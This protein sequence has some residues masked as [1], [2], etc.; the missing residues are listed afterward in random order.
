MATTNDLKNGLVL[1]LDGG[2]LWAVV[3]FQ[4][5]KPGKGGAFVRT[6]LKNV[7]SGKVVDKTFNAGVKVEVANVDKREMQFSY[8]DGDDFVFMDT[9]NY[10]MINVSRASVGSSADYLLENMLATLAINEGNVLYVDLPAAVEL[11]IAETEP[12]LQGDRSTGGTKPAKLETGA[13]IKVPLFITTGEKVKVDTRT[14]DY[15]GRA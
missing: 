2:E 5:V 10:D 8:M 15:L 6:K 3:E 14:G 9:E 4:H 1:K 12:G 11:I 13:E 7:M